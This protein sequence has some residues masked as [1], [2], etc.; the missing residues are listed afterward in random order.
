[1]VVGWALAMVVWKDS[2]AL[3]TAE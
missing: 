1:M 2:K 3:L